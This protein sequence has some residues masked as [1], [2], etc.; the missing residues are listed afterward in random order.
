[1]GEETKSPFDYQKPSEEMLPVIEAT[2]EAYKV[3]HAHLLTLP[4]SRERSVAITELETSAMW[5]VKGIVF[6]DPNT[7]F[8]KQGG[9]TGVEKS[10]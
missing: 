7:S 5:A 2:R 4:A 6:N 9:N 1:M 10:A 8:G 3:L